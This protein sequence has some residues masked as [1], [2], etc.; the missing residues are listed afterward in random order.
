MKEA[1]MVR[2]ALEYERETAAAERTLR[3]V[4]EA[5]VRELEARLVAAAAPWAPAF[6]VGDRVEILSRPYGASYGSDLI[7]KVGDV[8]EI[9]RDW[10]PPNGSGPL[11]YYVMPPCGNGFFYAAEQ[12]RAVAPEAP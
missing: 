3:L 4:A 9:D 12:L 1:D 10:D 8:I 5:R 11:D 6:A 7:G 2:A